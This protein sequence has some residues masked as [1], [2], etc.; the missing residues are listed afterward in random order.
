MNR[1]R[2]LVWVKGSTRFGEMFKANTVVSVSVSKIGKWFLSLIVAMIVG[3][4]VSQPQST[5]AQAER[6][7]YQSGN[8]YLIVEFLDDDSIHFELSAFGPGPSTNDPLYTTPMVH[9][10][11]YPGPSSFTDDG[12]GTLET[13]DIRVEVNTNSLC[14]TAT[15]K[16][17]DPDL[18]LT[19]I[20]PLNLDQ[21]WKGMTIAPE[22]FT[23]AYG[24]G[25]QFITPGS[26]EGD[27][28]G[29]VRSPGGESGNAQVGWNGGG[30]GNTQFPIVYFVG[31]NND[32]YALFMDNQYTQNWDFTGNPWKAEMWGDWLRFYVMTGPD[33]QDLRKDYMELVG[34]PLVPP[35]KMFGL[36]V[37]EY[38]FDNWA[39]LDDKLSTL[40]TNK[41]PIDGLVLDLQWFG[42]IIPDSDDSPMGSLTWDRSNF[43]DPEGKIA[44]LRSDEGI[45][46]I[47]IEESYVG[48]NLPEHTELENRGYLARDCETCGATYLDSNPWWGKGG[49]IDWTDDVAGAFWH[50]WKREPLID[51]GII[52]HW[53]DLGEPE[54]YNAWAWYWGI[55]GDHKPLHQH[56]DVHNLYNLEWSQSIYE[57]YLRNGRTQRPFILARSGTSGSQ[58]YGVAMW[59]GDIG[60]NLSSLATHLNAQMHMSMSGIDYYGADI[61]G[62]VRDALDGDLD[63]MYTQ[64]FANGMVFDVPGRP[65]AENLC[66]CKETAPDRIGDLQSNLE[67]V[68]QRYELS[69]YVYSLAHRAYLYGEPVVPPLVYYYQ[70]DANVREMGGEK[71]LG[72]ELLVAAVTTYG[73][74]ER[75]VYLPAG[76]WINYH[77][78]EWFHSSGEWFGPFP[79]YLDGKFKLP[80]F[81]RAGAIIPQMYV[82]DKTMNIMGKRTDGSTRDE[83]VVGVYADSTPSTFTLYE[84]DGETIAYQNGEV[85]TTVISQQRAEDRVT[86]TIGGASG[87]YAGAPTSRDN[88]VKLAVNDPESIT[89]VTL[90]GTSL[91]QYNTQAEFDA[92]ASGWYNAG[93]NLIVA[94][95]SDMNVT[96]TKTFEFHL[97]NL[98]YLP[99][100]LNSVG[101]WDGGRIRYPAV[102][103]DGG[104]YKMW[105]VGIDLNGVGR[106]GYATSPDGITWTKSISN[107]VLDVGAQGE[108]DA[109]ELETPFVI[110]EGPTSYKMWYSGCDADGIWHI[111]YATSS[112]GINWVKHPSNPVLDPGQDNWNNVYMHGPFILYEDSLYKMWLHTVGD[113]G[114]GRTPYMA[115]ATSTNGITWTLAIT[116][117]LFSLDPAHDWES[118]WI[119]GP[120]VLHTGSDYQMWYSGSE[121][122]GEG[123]TGY[124]TASDETTWTK[125]NGGS[126]PVLSGTGGEWDQ[127]SAVDPYVLYEGGIYT[128]YYDNNFTSIGVATSTNGIT[129]TKSISNPV[130]SPG[131]PGQ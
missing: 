24:L 23:H 105:Y 92:V 33:L 117:P 77:T 25:Q 48:K 8:N 28:I 121:G 56:G 69:P 119:H 80:M 34:H 55:P 21:D 4:M 68:R 87:S 99:I 102:I 111:G 60:S 122:G 44:N 65:H 71:L 36:W 118:N 72:R 3:I 108:W 2:V 63:E 45:G 126:D 76:D 74:T 84:D 101:D 30:I 17:K 50:D 120:S 91:P 43:P 107:P 113:D 130:L 26:S 29:R 81:A 82:D 39:E 124:A 11:N 90:N 112:D 52:G 97:G 78:N 127:G 70:S 62:F 5:L 86:V 114:S 9:K 79:E 22:S 46:I 125:Y 85:R 116:N 128:M 88:V 20:C 19:T 100:I 15:D 27:W 104:T 67:N 103:T 89:S 57:G 37:S 14:V 53:T 10:T 41:F 1:N 42:G 110:K 131:A 16:T 73:E 93:N 51:D 96:S 13:P 40:R 47:L 64:W 7:K 32:S 49:M 123:H 75:N 18:I 83:L 35:K 94:K 106:I 95:S 98:I 54:A 115:Y 59:S 61:G 66:N 12:N 129:W 109:A 31:S 6:V 38:G 58:R